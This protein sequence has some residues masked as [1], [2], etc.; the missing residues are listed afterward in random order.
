MSSRSTSIMRVERGQFR[1]R[2]LRLEGV[3]VDE[4]VDDADE[5]E[6]RRDRDRGVEVVVHRGQELFAQGPRLVAGG[7]YGRIARS[8]GSGRAGR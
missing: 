3:L 8:A 2:L 5:V 1:G 4:L 6:E 7:G